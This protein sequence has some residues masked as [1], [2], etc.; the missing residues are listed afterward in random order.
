VAQRNCGGAPTGAAPLRR[1]DALPPLQ[2]LLC[3]LWME[4]D[5]LRETL[6]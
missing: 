3:D 1:P 4:V 5:S 6:P 2:L